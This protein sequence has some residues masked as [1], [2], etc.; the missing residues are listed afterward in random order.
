VQYFLK[1]LLFF[2]SLTA[3]YP[4]TPLAQGFS[5]SQKGVDNVKILLPNIISCSCIIEFTFFIG[6][7]D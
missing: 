3:P 7:R 4:W 5:A 1:N 6:S 2:E